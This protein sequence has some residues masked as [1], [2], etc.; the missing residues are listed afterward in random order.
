MGVVSQRD[1]DR[2]GGGRCLEGSLDERS[3]YDGRGR[4]RGRGR[5]RVQ[6]VGAVCHLPVVLHYLLDDFV[7]LVVKHA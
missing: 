5:A 2:G 6:Q 1:G 4:G 3:P 7:L